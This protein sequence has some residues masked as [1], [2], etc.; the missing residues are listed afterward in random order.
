MM[1]TSHLHKNPTIVENEYHHQVFPPLWIDPT[2]KYNY[3]YIN[4]ESQDEESAIPQLQRPS[5][6]DF[7][8]ELKK[9]LPQLLPLLIKLF[10]AS[11][12]TTRLENITQIGSL[13]NLDQIVKSALETINMTELAAGKSHA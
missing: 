13:L 7:I 8:H 9:L 11:N 1:T 5:S 4:R 2:P 12:F 6:Q 10:F 3:G